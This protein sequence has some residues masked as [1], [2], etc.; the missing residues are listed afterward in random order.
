MNSSSVIQIQMLSFLLSLLFSRLI[1]LNAV[2]VPMPH[3]LLLPQG[4][5]PPAA[6]RQRMH[7][8]VSVSTEILPKLLKI[9]TETPDWQPLT[10]PLRNLKLPLASAWSTY[11]PTTP[12]NGQNKDIP[13]TNLSVNENPVFE[14]IV[15]GAWKSNPPF[16]MFNSSEMLDDKFYHRTINRQN[17]GFIGHFIHKLAKSEKQN[18][19]KPIY[20]ERSAEH[21]SP[22]LT[23]KS[24]KQQPIEQKQWL[25]KK[26]GRYKIRPTI[27]RRT[28]R[29]D[30]EIPVT[31]IIYSLK[32]DTVHTTEVIP[33][34]QNKP[35]ETTIKM[36]TTTNI[37]T[38]EIELTTLSEKKIARTT[39]SSIL[40]WPKDFMDTLLLSTTQNLS[41]DTFST[42]DYNMVLRKS[43]ESPLAL[44]ALNIPPSLWPQLPGNITKLGKPYESRSSSEEPALCVPITINEPSISNPH[45]L[46]SVE[47]VYCFPLPNTTN[48]IDDFVT[49][50]HMTSGIRL[51]WNIR[52]LRTILTFVIVGKIFIL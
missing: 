41:N 42:E 49:K 29:D 31:E 6:P 10:V 40:D 39:N 2:T 3:T 13:L 46:I 52:E 16:K 44:S 30:Q 33:S 36:T 17:G 23:E 32:N 34:T 14:S 43:S 24:E 5:D 38:P 9:P 20:Y 7:Y 19:L 22:K 25:T 18:I 11:A 1:L 48:K 4:F 12:L 21:K 15:Y 27:E 28:I 37:P 50:N 51:H 47:R 26:P 35:H 45:K 8:P